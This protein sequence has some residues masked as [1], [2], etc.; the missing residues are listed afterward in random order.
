MTQEMELVL[1]LAAEAEKGFDFKA[2]SGIEYTIENMGSLDTIIAIADG[3]GTVGI[4]MQNMTGEKAEQLL[5][6]AKILIKRCVIKP[7]IEENGDGSLTIEGKAKMPSQDIDA[8]V[9]QLYMRTGFG[10]MSQRVIKKFR[11]KQPRKSDRKP[12]SSKQKATNGNN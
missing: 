10:P 5:N 6:N 11:N 3:G 4:N 1:K 9:T 7:K 12:G 2:P 8:I